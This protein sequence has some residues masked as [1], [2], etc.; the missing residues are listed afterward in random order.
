MNEDPE[1]AEADR[2]EQDLPADAGEDDG[3]V[4]VPHREDLDPEAPVADV[5]EQALPAD[6]DLDDDRR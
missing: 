6:V 4:R 5:L 2:Q 3:E 1:A